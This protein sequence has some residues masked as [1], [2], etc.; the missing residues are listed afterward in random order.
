MRLFFLLAMMM[1]SGC[2]SLKERSPGIYAA[3]SR[4]HEAVVAGEVLSRRAEFFTSTAL[5][6]IDIGSESDAMELSVGAY[7]A[8]EQSHHEK[9]APERGCLTIN[10]YQANGSPVM[11]FIEYKQ[12]GRNWLMNY[13]NVHLPPKEGFA[14]FVDKALCPDEFLE[15]ILSAKASERQ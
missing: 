11:L 8:V 14:G 13:T 5:Q 1:I 7:I 6:D 4:Y 12:A 3:F 9:S 15:E 2:A 10:G